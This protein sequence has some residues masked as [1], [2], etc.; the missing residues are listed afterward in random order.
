MLFSAEVNR[1]FHRILLVNKIILKIDIKL[2]ALKQNIIIY[3]IGSRVT[4]IPA[5]DFMGI[6]LSNFA[7]RDLC[8]FCQSEYVH[9]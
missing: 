7:L 1:M 3:V 2:N 5:S 4:A 9:S 8:L 6:G